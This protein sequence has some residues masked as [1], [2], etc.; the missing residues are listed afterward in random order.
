MDIQADRRIVSMDELITPAQLQAELPIPLEHAVQIATWTKTVENILLGIDPRL[1]VWL[2]PCSIH[3][4]QE[5]L[6]LAKRVAE[7][8]H[9]FG[10]KLF[11]VFRGMVAKPRSVILGP[12]HWT[13]LINDPRLD[14]SFDMDVGMRLARQ[15]FIDITAMG[16]PVGMEVLDF[17]DINCLDDLISLAAIGAR[18]SES[19]R[20]R[21]LASGLSVPV[22]F[23]NS[24]DG[25]LDIAIKGILTARQPQVLKL[26]NKNN[27]SCRIKTAGNPFS[28]LVLRGGSNGPNFSAKHIAA[29][30]HLLD[31]EGILTGLG[32]DCNHANSG[33]NA[34]KQKLVA[35]ELAD[36]LRAGEKAIKVVMIETNLR[37]GKQSHW[38]VAP[39]QLVPGVSITDDCEAW[40]QDTLPTL[41]ELHNAVN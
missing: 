33:K 9:H 39:S 27:V 7:A 38:G 1:L 17:E 25:N 10:D 29:A 2:G 16:L 28:F 14:G 20:P 4:I 5:A 19:Q 6:E 8:H 23:K 31:K 26:P 22:P 30:K 36:Q 40:T 24:T 35:Q 21:Q 15:L 18:S 12:Q 13:G 37:A 41:E 34:L 11:I 32:I 3:N